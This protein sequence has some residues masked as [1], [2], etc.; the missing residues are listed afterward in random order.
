MV[1][2][3]ET[4]APTHVKVPSPESQ[5]KSSSS[6]YS[7]NFGKLPRVRAEQLLIDEL[8]GTFLIRE[9]EH[10]PGD[11]TLSIKDDA[12]IQHYRVKLDSIR[13][14][15]TVDDEI[16]FPDLRLLV[17]HYELDADG[18]CC[19]LEK[20]LNNKQ[21]TVD[22]IKIG[23]TVQQQQTSPVVVIPSQ[24][25][26]TIDCRE[27]Y[28]GKLIGSGE[29]AEVYEGTY[30]KVRVAIK[31]LKE[32][33]SAA[34]FRHEADIMSS[35]KHRNLVHFLG[36]AQKPDNVIY[37]V[38][39]FMAKGSLLHYLTTRGRSVISQKD[40]LG[41]A[42]DTCEGLTYLEENHIVHRDVAAS[43]VL[44]ADDNTAKVADFG[45]AKFVETTGKENGNKDSNGNMIIA[46][47]IK[48]RTKWT[49]PEALESKRYTHKSDMWSYGILLW[50]IFSYGRCPYP[51]IPANDVLI[52]LKQ[53]HRMEP[54]DGCP[55]EVGDIMRQ[56]WLADPDRRPSFD[57]V[58]ERLR[59]ISSSIVCS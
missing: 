46:E 45:L 12:K 39:E 53:G 4:L 58:L 35:L 24:T 32:A 48:C 36:V 37:I 31:V 41:F 27:L 29:F 47:K 34:L 14:T 15:Y 57:Q 16:F 9:S 10:Y 50:E 7:W 2:D 25:S 22:S 13:H 52:N 21:D 40:L 3:D 20:A 17:E 49:A 1:N 59:R 8:M 23:G 43:N 11:L 55:Q 42:T 44:I 38:T 28:L 33:T 56:A 18:L 30:R 26:S 6:S 5:L 51:R 54:P 19:R